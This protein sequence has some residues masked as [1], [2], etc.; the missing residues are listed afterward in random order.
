MASLFRRSVSPY[1][2]LSSAFNEGKN[3][4]ICGGDEQVDMGGHDAKIVQPKGDL[5][6][7]ARKTGNMVF[8]S[9]LHS[10]THL[11]SLVRGFNE[12]KRRQ[13]PLRYRSCC[14][15][16]QLRLRRSASFPAR[17]LPRTAPACCGIL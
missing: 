17:R 5:A 14:Y 3:G 11:R 10:K 6:M 15:P 16:R 1:G 12:L 4:F 13:A 9:T 2:F 8:L 7:A